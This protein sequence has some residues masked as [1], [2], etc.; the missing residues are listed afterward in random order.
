[1]STHSR[2]LRDQADRLL[3]RAATLE[4]IDCVLENVKHG[5]V[6]RFERPYNRTTLTY[7]AIAIEV[8][9]ENA[10]YWYHTGL[11]SASRMTLSQLVDRFVR[12]NV[13]LDTLV[14]LE[15]PCTRTHAELCTRTHMRS[16]D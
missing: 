9:G 1:M 4:K 16:D 11:S 2:L 5:T 8:P 6:I 13:N 12:W 15:P 10:V 3:M 14:V 7:A